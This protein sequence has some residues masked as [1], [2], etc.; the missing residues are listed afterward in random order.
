MDKVFPVDFKFYATEPGVKK[1]LILDIPLQSADS[2]P[3]CG[4]LG[5]MLLFVCTGGPFSSSPGPGKIGK[6]HDNAWWEG[7]TFGAQC[8]VCK[9]FGKDKSY[10]AESDYG[11]DIQKMAK[12]FEGLHSVTK[13]D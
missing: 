9:G 7:Q 6:W 10:K 4:G 1:A 5:N 12:D 8:P 3:N 11:I 2:C 13:D